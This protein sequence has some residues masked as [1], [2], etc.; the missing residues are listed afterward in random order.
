M[1]S[2]KCKIL[3]LE[4]VDVIKQHD[5]GVSCHAL[6]QTLNMGK[7]Y[8]QNI[9]GCAKI[10][11]NWGK[12]QNVKCWKCADSERWTE[13]S[14]V[15]VILPS[16]MKEHSFDWQVVAGTGYHLQYGAWLFL[17]H[18][19]QWLA[20]SSPEVPWHQVSSLIW[21][22][23]WSIHG[24][25][26]QLEEPSPLSAMSMNIKSSSKWM[27]LACCIGLYHLDHSFKWVTRH[28]GKL[29]K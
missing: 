13:Q 26:W 17:F 16:Q 7:S 6:A 27:K 18:C 25:H 29:I 11:A 23:S 9:S 28:G 4:H 8:I 21:W 1:A 5:K 10:I 19:I 14:H 24:Y 3:N 12:L 22:S 15:S 2:R 20:S